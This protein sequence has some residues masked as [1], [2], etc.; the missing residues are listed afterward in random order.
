VDEPGDPLRVFEGRPGLW[1]DV[2][3][4]LVGVI[5]VGAARRPRME[6]ERGE[7]GRPGHLRHLGHAECV[8]VAA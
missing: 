6:V 1:I 8:R 3:S 7:V 2:D 4:E 5:D